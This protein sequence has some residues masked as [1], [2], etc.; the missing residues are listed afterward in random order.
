MSATL[1]HAI[2]EQLRCPPDYFKD[3]VHRHLYVKRAEIIEQAREWA[4]NADAINALEAKVFAKGTMAPFR[5]FECTPIGPLAGTDDSF[6]M[7]GGGVTVAGG[8]GATA[9][10]KAK[11]RDAA[12]AF[13]QR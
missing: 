13:R 9:A 1:Q 7:I 10:T 3:I 11:A 4:A 8:V 12:R 6:S 2:K 5:I